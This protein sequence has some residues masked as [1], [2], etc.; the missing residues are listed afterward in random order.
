MIPTF[1]QAK[2][3][4]GKVAIHL[5]QTPTYTRQRKETKENETNNL[6]HVPGETKLQ[7]VRTKGKKKTISNKYTIH[8]L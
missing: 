5:Y 3:Q 7:D 4:E 8:L 2:E 1:H 6:K